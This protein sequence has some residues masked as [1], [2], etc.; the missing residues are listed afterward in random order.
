MSDFVQTL[1]KLKALKLSEY[2]VD[3]IKKLLSDISKV[4][5][6]A[7][8]LHKG[9]TILRVRPNELN[10]TFEII[11]QLSF[12]PLKFNKTFQRA[13]TPS[14][15]MFYGCVVPENIENEECDYAKMTAVIETSKLYRKGIEIGEEKITF[16]HWSVTKDIPLIAIVYNQDFIEASSHTNE[17]HIAYQRFLHQNNPSD[18]LKSNAINEFLASEFAK[19]EITND[20]DYL[21]SALY[22][23]LVVQKGYAGVYYPSVRADGKGF[24]VAIHP[25]FVESCMTPIV[26]GEC[27]LYKKGNHIVLDND[28]ITVIETGQTNIKFEP[29]TDPASHSG[30]EICYKILNNEISI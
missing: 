27:S 1:D 29:I 16:S 4:V 25:D 6:I 13:S 26:A 23:E 9:K 30:R 7:M 21:I 15:T 14:T 3:E 19:S 28:T 8:T 2:P 11:S 10:E 20:F 22:S 17:L 24:N 5:E 18:V 12:K